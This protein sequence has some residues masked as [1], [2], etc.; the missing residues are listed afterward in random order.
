MPGRPGMYYCAAG[1]VIAVLGMVN[2]IVVGYIYLMGGMVNSNS[3][4]MVLI[5]N[6]VLVVMGLA[7]RRVNR[8]GKRIGG[9]EKDPGKI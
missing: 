6:T 4:G 1:I 3:L 9:L 5:M 7:M 8:K 2:M